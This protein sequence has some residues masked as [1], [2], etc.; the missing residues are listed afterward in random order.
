MILNE[1]EVFRI[2]RDYRIDYRK[3]GWTY[4]TSVAIVRNTNVFRFKTC[5]CCGATTWMKV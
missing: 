3:D 1:S 2:A 4:V 5:D